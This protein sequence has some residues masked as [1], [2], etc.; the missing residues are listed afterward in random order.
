MNLHNEFYASIPALFAVT[1]QCCNRPIF[2]SL[3]FV[4]WQTQHHQSREECLGYQSK[5]TAIVVLLSLARVFL[6][7]LGHLTQ[8]KTV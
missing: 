1:V 5:L 3:H 4:K 7:V 6:V 2:S 8:K